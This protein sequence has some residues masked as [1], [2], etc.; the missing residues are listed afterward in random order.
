LN[1]ERGE[2]GDWGERRKGIIFIKIFYS[3]EWEKE[4]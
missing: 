4:V 1:I 3:K 2:E